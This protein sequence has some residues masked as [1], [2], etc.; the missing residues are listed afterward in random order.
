M[1]NI[2][3]ISPGLKETRLMKLSELFDKLPPDK[4]DAILIGVTMLATAYNPDLP[5]KAS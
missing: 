3:T 2:N 5:K 1:G 4:Q